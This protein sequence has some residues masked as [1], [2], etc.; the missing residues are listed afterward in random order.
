MRKTGRRVLVTSLFAIA[1]LVPASTAVA[2]PS[3]NGCNGLFEV[4]RFATF[5]N[6]GDTHGHA[7]VHH[8]FERH[9]CD[10]HDH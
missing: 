10:H 3:A 6:V 5:Q 1:A 7:T 4:A 9:G 8:Q 2:N